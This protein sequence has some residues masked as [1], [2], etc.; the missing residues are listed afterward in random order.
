MT[1]A[2]NE[3]DQANG[4]DMKIT[5]VQL[6]TQA[7]QELAEHLEEAKKTPVLLIASLCLMAY[8]EVS[9]QP[10]TTRCLKDPS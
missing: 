8:F 10:V 7:L 3:Y 5:A 6:Y 1:T 2:D 9:G 4:L